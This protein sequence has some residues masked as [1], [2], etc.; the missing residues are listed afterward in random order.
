[1]IT[2]NLFERIKWGDEMDCCTINAEMF[3]EYHESNLEARNKIIEINL[4]LVRQIANIYKSK[5]N[6]DYDDL[7]QAG[8]IVLVLAVDGFD[9]TK[10]YK[11]SI[12]ASSMIKGEILKYITSNLHNFHIPQT[13]Q[14]NV[15]KYKKLKEQNKL[16]ED[17]E[18][19]KM[20]NISIDQLNRIKK[21][22]NAIDSINITSIDDVKYSDSDITIADELKSDINI[23]EDV[24]KKIL[25]DE[26]LEILNNNLNERELDILCK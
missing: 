16:L 23:E 25:D 8:C 5:I 2:Y 19:S 12:Y 7:F 22:S 4:N 9:E 3:N 15:Y 26:I 21:Q 6:M 11:F 24:L 20:M 14:S 13:V 18:I 1:M 10:G 17:N